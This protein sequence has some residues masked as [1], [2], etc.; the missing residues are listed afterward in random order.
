MPRGPPLPGDLDRPIVAVQAQ[1]GPLVGD[2]GQQRTNEESE[3]ARISKVFASTTV[4]PFGTSASA[5]TTPSAVSSSD[6]AYAQNG[7]A[8]FVNAS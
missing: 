5:E 4:H 6:E 3:A 1:S 7:H 8:R 2:A